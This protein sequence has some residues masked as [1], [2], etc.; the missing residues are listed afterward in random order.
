MP[1]N[2]MFLPLIR[3]AF[4]DC[5]VIHVSRHRLDVAVSML[6]NKLNHGFHCAYRIED[7]VH[8][9][10]AV[11]A[12]HEY[13]REQFDT[14]EFK[15]HYE[16]LASDPESTVRELLDFIGLPFEERCLSFH[17]QRRFVATPSYRQVD[18]KISNSSVGRH[19]NYQRRLDKILSPG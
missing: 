11:A 14:R 2:E 12:L 15:L 17:E 6:S 13:Y 8:H 19:R 18:S 1:F 16:K 7:I 3:L 5:P 4:P 10:D 9:L